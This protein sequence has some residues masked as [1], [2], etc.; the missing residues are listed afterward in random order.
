MTLLAEPTLVQ[1]DEAA[2]GRV[3]ALLS[4]EEQARVQRIVPKLR[5]DAV[6]ASLAL[7]RLELAGATGRAPWAI[8]FDRRCLRC[9]SPSHGRPVAVD[10]GVEFSVARTEG[11]AAV[12]I[13]STAIGVDVERRDRALMFHE[14]LPLLSEVERSS[15]E[16]NGHRP[17]DVW[18]LKEAVGKA[19]GIGLVGIQAVTVVTDDDDDH[20]SGWR[21]IREGDGGFISA[22]TFRNPTVVVGLS[23]RREPMDIRLR[24]C[25]LSDYLDAAA[26]R[27][28]E[29][30][31]RGEGI[32]L[33]RP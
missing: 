2:D 9:G 4:E 16:R 31:I 30:H 19:L 22:T 32:L 13:A 26:A 1:V 11:W 12:A 20:P 15:L 29:T 28:T 23:I 21:R 17:L 3:S 6:A 27:L 10:A 8:A 5:R 7:A 24:C 14:L 18:V 33:P 25:G